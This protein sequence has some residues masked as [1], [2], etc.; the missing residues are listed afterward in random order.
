[1]IVDKKTG[2]YCNDYE[3]TILDINGN[4]FY[5]KKNVNFPK[6]M[7]FNL[8]AGKYKSLNNIF[9]LNKPVFYRLPKLYKPEKKTPLKSPKVSYVE[10]PN[11]ASIDVM[12]G[13][14]YINPFYKNNLCQLAFLYWHEIGHFFYYSEYKCDRFAEN[15]ML[16]Y[17]YNPSQITKAVL[18]GLNC[19]INSSF[20]RAKKVYKS[21]KK[22]I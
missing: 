10:N 18:T 14:I 11:K 20:E 4:F 9:A 5:N 3:V 7:Y 13:N 2:F 16:K 8:P 22:N 21:I 6:P 15:K 12:T 17:G 1:M 19:N